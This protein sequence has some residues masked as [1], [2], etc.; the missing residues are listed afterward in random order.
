M[1]WK[2]ESVIKTPSY[3]LPWSAPED[4]LLQEI[5]NATG[6]THWHL[7][8]L[9]VYYK[10]GGQ[11]V[12]NSVQC[13]ERWTKYLC[14]TPKNKFWT[15]HEDMQLLNALLEGERRWPE[16]AKKVPGR[17]EKGLKKRW[18]H[19][20]KKNESEI[21]AE[22][23]KIG[24]YLENGDSWDTHLI[25]KMIEIKE[26]KFAESQLEGIEILF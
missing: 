24:R 10:S 3:N 19:L 5:V 2:W 16:I 18:L 25:R 14:S 17:F 23:K 26:K 22:A 8:A 4:K 20:L 1:K 15:H 12:R 13:W 11:F 7:I 6:P 21:T 9:E